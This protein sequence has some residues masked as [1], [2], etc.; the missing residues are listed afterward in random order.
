MG[1]SRRRG[2]WGLN[3]QAKLAIANCCCHL[4]KRNKERFRRL[5]YYFGVFYYYYYC[6]CCCSH[7]IVV[8][9]C[10]DAP[11]QKVIVAAGMCVQPGRNL[12]GNTLLFTY[13]IV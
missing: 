9:A 13:G 4:A 5:P 11:H 8:L 2:N 12:T 1:A 3:T 10:S 7:I 6:S